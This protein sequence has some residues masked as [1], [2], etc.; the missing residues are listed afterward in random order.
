MTKFIVGR[1]EETEAHVQEALRLS[2]RDT[3]A[4]HWMG[5]VGTAKLAQRERVVEG[6]R[7]AGVP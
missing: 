5:I 2:P 3:F 1:G 6:L 4:Y 7:K